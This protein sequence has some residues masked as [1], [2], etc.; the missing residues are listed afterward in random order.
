MLTLLLMTS[1]YYNEDHELFRSQLRRF[2]DTE[3]EPHI[4]EW[5]EANT[6]PRELYKKAADIG[7][8]GPT[9][10][11]AYGGSEAADSATDYFFGNI[12][13]EE[14]SRAGAGGLNA[15]LFSHG[16]ALPP[17]LN[18][19]T[20]EQ[21]QRFMPGV[22][23]GE[24]ISALA[25][26]EPSGGSDVANMKTTAVR[27]G[28]HYIVNGS[29]TFITSG[30]RADQYT[31]GVR[32]GDAGF[33]GI[34]LLVIDRDTPGFSRTEL[35]K[36]GWW[37]SDTATLY[38]DNCRVPVANRLGDENAGFLGI[39]LNF[40]SERLGLAAMAVGLA[41]T[42]IDEALAWARE[43]KT[44]GKSLLG[45]QVIRHKLV[46]MQGRCNAARALL[47]KTTLQVNAGESPIPELCML[48]TFSTDMLE[49]VAGE[50]VQILGGAGYMRGCKS[51]RIFRETKVLSIGG[52][53]SEVMKD[54][55]ARQLGW[56]ER[57]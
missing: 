17:I 9:F 37:C 55:A 2:V 28:D 15:S 54:L 45:H 5:E 27:D 53:A 16:I 30:M 10:P 48:K 22:L 43:R 8:L 52:G 35:K 47:E 41:Q 25:I 39:M 3:V 26:T 12:V 36:M 29:K 21:K 4:N 24:K 1:P 31:V 18:L 49:Y 32:T 57:G 50:A 56:T 51:E 23:S 34:S 19:G 11:E 33:G 46:D 44:F 13:A 38:F 42:C 7:L 20:E 40:N 6:F 14:I